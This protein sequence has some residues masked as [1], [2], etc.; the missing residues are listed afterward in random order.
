[1]SNFNATLMLILLTMM[2]YFV[3]M[4]INILFDL[5]SFLSEL[6][7]ACRIEITGLV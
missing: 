5:S 2:S 6:Y 1:M 7:G 3:N 4:G